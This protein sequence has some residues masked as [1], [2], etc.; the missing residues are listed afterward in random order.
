M[1]D[2]SSIIKI[3]ELR[4]ELSQAR[5]ILMGS[6]HDFNELYPALSSMHR[7]LRYYRIGQEEL[8]INPAM[9]SEFLEQNLGAN[10]FA[11]IKADTLEQIQR[12]NIVA[13]NYGELP[14]SVKVDPEDSKRKDLLTAMIPLCFIS[15]I[16]DEIESG[17]LEIQ[18]V[19]RH[20]YI[21]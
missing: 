5:F 12:G 21:Q 8:P 10:D 18:P 2:L 7:Q 1:T 3:A 4:I 13:L 9:L 17:R 20:V 15:C 19:E 16:L 14:E 11:A 6:Q